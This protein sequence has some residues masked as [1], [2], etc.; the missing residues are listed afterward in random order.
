MLAGNVLLKGL[1]GAGVALF[2]L[3]S[4]DAVYDD[5]SDAGAE[6]VAQVAVERSRRRWDLGHMSIM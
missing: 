3:S 5:R 2:S 4:M 1:E 6:H